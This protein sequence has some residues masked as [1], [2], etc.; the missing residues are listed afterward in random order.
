MFAWISASGSERRLLSEGRLR[1]PTPY[2]IAIMTFAMMVVG[3][4]GL[5]LSNAAGIVA[6]GVESR[7]AVQL[8]DSATLPKA[9]SVLRRTPGV[10]RAEP[11]PEAKMRQTLERWLGPDGLGDELPVPALVNVDLS[12]KATVSAIQGQLERSVPGARMEKPRKA[13]SRSRA[14]VP[15]PKV[16]KN[17][18]AKCWHSCRA[19]RSRSQP[20]WNEPGRFC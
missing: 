17:P 14:G 5:A 18:A 16:A 4:A 20:S 6:R 2:V 12:A 3:A 9:L 11:V 19:C 1:G 13:S 15:A 10:T 7:Y 8:V